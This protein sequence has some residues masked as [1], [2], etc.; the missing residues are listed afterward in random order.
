MDQLPFLD[1][2]PIWNWELM[3]K[4]DEVKTELF[5]GERVVKADLRRVQF[6]TGA[7][8]S[9]LPLPAAQMW[10]NAGFEF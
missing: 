8:S 1:E 7:A 3:A 10:W 6:A 4:N 5:A 2:R 9:R